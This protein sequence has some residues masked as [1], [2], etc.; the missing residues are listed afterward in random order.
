MPNICSKSAWLLTRFFFHKTDN[1]LVG[2]G[3]LGNILIT[4]W[5]L[6]TPHDHWEF[7]MQL[8]IWH[9]YVAFFIA[10]HVITTLVLQVLLKISIWLN[11]S[12]ILL[13]DFI[14][15]VINSHRQT[16]DLNWY[17][18]STTNA[19]PNQMRRFT[20]SGIIFTN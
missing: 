6:S 10:A 1:S 11:V 7:H 20:R 17:C 9:V 4:S 16:V 12:C 3:S 18:P 19:T 14:L 15:D 13:A 8:C 5:L 2:R